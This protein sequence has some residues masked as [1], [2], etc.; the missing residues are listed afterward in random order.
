MSIKLCAEFPEVFQN[1]TGFHRCAIPS[2]DKNTGVVV[3]SWLSAP[4]PFLAL[5]LLLLLLSFGLRCAFSSSCCACIPC[6][7]CVC[8]LVLLVLCFCFVSDS[9]LAFYC[10]LL[11]GFMP[12][13][14]FSFIFQCCLLL[15]RLVFPN[16]EVWD[17]IHGPTAM[18]YTPT[19]SDLIRVGRASMPNRSNM[20]SHL[21]RVGRVSPRPNR[22]NR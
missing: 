11:T 6:F 12:E 20:H 10:V 9:R 7:R 2:F 16:F 21:I 22:N 14:P 3:A 1:V 4:T 13:V 17:S 19:I 15:F 8:L 5:Y 18:T